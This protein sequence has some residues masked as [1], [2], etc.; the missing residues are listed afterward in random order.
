MTTDTPTPT[1]VTS[2]D[3][4]AV[5]PVIALI[6]SLLR[7]G[8]DLELIVLTVDLSKAEMAEL[9]SLAKGGNLRVRLLPICGSSLSGSTLNSPHL[10]QAA[11]A[12]LFIPELLPSL[13]KAIWLDADTLVM[14]RLSPLWK[15]NLGNALVAAVPDPFI[16]DEE[17]IATKSRRG[18]YFNSGVMV[19]NLKAWRVD[20]VSIVAKKMMFDSNLIC[21]DQSILNRI[22][23]GRVVFIEDYWNFHILRFSEY[24]ATSRRK[25]PVILHYC[26]CRKP[27]VEHVA[28]CRIFL[29]F[30]P[31]KRRK[32][33]LEQLIQVPRL[34]KI[35]LAQRRVFGLILGR[36]KHWVKT[37]QVIEAAI[38]AVKL[39]APRLESLIFPTLSRAGRALRKFVLRH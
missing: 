4:N 25:L 36:R 7:T 22:C 27:W 5:I 26:G 14:G 12:R 32:H 23:F 16:S 1:L 29:D 35:E 13:S 17:I 20:N 8:D 11:Y 18:L 2:A 19:M 28:F 3:H 31:S 38:F 34:R 6:G 24:S 21:E 9:M 10:S 15:T 37:V 30:L 39:R 33:T